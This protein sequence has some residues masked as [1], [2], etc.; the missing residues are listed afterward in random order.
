MPDLSRLPAR[1]P[2]RDGRAVGRRRRRELRRLSPL[3][4]APGGGA[5]APPLPLALRRPMFGLLG[6]VYPKAD[7]APRVLRAKTT[8]EAL[9]RDSVEAYF[10][11]MSMLRD[12]DAA[13]LCS[14]R[15]QAPSSPATTRSK[16]SA[17]T[18][19]APNTDDPLALIQYLDLKTYLVGDINTKV[20]RASMA[21]SLEVREPLMDHPL[22]E[23]L[24]TLPSRSSCADGEG[25]WLLK[26]A[27]E[28]LLPRRPAVPAED[29]VRRAAG[30]LVSR[31]A[32]QRVREAV[33]GERLAD[34]GLFN[35]RT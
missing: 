22:V 13:Q 1:T 12:D 2:A 10:H 3:P 21:H 31:A 19:R 33:L 15:L 14:R 9:A 34:S 11:S 24:A 26:K 18:P 6:R 35:P 7:W 16:C 27:M 23:W 4:A 29:G 20:D 25:K 32:A 8:F 28:P 17:G 5:A 30:R